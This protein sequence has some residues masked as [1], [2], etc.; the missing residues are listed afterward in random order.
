M[1]KESLAYKFVGGVSYPGCNYFD[2]ARIVVN[3]ETHSVDARFKPGLSETQN[4]KSKYVHFVTLD[5]DK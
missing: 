5:P 4:P 3:V 1:P 2:P